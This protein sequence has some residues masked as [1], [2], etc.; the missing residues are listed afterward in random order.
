MVATL[1]VSAVATL[2]ANQSAQ[3]RED[4]L[5]V[6]IEHAENV[7]A[8]HEPMVMRPELSVRAVRR[9]SGF[10]ASALVERLAERNGLPKDVTDE[11]LNGVRQRL[12]ASTGEVQED[13]EDR[14]KRLFREKNLDDDV[15]LEAIEG[16]DHDFVLSALQL[17][18]GLSSAAINRILGTRNGEL[19]TALAWKAQLSMR[20]AMRLQTSLGKVLPQKIVNARNGTDYPLPPDRLDLL[21]EGYR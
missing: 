16:G 11:L 20:T 19:I 15:V 21:I 17:M 7:Q 6:V 3:I 8:W 9:I 12:G 4:S 13:S 18:S 2:L 10:V 1:D 14:A 5:D